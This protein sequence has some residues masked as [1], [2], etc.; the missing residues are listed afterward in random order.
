[1]PRV[2]LSVF[3]KGYWDKETPEGAE[4]TELHIESNG[5]IT[6]YGNPEPEHDCDVMG[7]PTIG[8]VIFFLK[9]QG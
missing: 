4:L 8:H 5:D 9:G 1:M 7:C 2:E 3:P 6:G